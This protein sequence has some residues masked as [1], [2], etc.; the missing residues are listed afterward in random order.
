MTVKIEFNQKICNVSQQFTSNTI[1]LGIIFSFQIQRWA[2]LA[3]FVLGMISF[4]LNMSSHIKDEN[5]GE[6]G[7]ESDKNTYRVLNRDTGKRIIGK[8][9][10]AACIFIYQA[11]VF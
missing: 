9:L 3:V 5:D 7:G 8:A 10:D 6:K 2:H 1:V 4:V 11:A